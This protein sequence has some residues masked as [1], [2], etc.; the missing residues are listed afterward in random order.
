MTQQDLKNYI[1]ESG[2][3][4]LDFITMPDF[5]VLNYLD[6]SVLTA[7]QSLYPTLTLKDLLCSNVWFI[8]RK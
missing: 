7:A 3:K 1:E 4:T 8:G 5:K 6:D 2:F